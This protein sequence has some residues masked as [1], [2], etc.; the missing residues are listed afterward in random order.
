MRRWIDLLIPLLILISAVALRVQDGTI[1]TELR[2]RV[3]DT[4]QRLQPR[5]YLDPPVRILDIDE[6][7]LR[8]FG[9]WPWPR[10]FLARI[11]NRLTEAGVAAIALDMLQQEPDRTGPESLLKQWQGRPNFATLQEAIKQLP[12]PDA[13]YIQALAS[14][15]TVLAFAVNATPGGRAPLCKVNF[16][17]LGSAGDDPSSYLLNLPGVTSAL[18]AFENA[19]AG[20]GATNALPDRDGIVRRVPLAVAYQGQ[21]CGNLVAEALRVAQGAGNY[22]I[23]LTGANGEEN[24]GTRTGL[25]AI[26]IGN[27]IVP[28][29]G[30][31]Q[32]LLYDSNTRPERFLSIARFM[33]PNFDASALANNIVLIG[34]TAEG[35]KD[36]K[37]SPLDPSMAGVEINAQLIEQILGS[38]YLSRPDYAYG[39][40]LLGLVLFGLALMLMLHFLGAIWSAGVTVLAIAFANG[41]S[42]YAFS[43]HGLLYDPAFPSL[44]AVA[45]YI[46]GSLMGYLR[47][48]RARHHVHQVVGMYVSPLVVDEIIKTG[49]GVELGGE[50]RELSVMFSDI[51]DFTKIAEKLNPQELTHLI[52]ST[53][54]PLTK[55]IYDHRGMLDKYI[56][57]CIMAFWSAPLH[58]PDHARHSL[59]AA[60][61]MRRSLTQ[62]NGH[63]AQEAQMTGKP[64]TPV[65]VGIGI[66]SGPCSVGNMG[67]AQRVAYSALGDT[68]NLASRL[69]SLTRS[70]GVHI[71]VGEETASQAPEMALL[72][73]DRVQVKGRS[74]PLAIYTLL[75]AARDAAFEKL[76]E[77]QGRFLAAYRSKNWVA[78]AAA[79]GECRAL[80]PDLSEL[81]ELFER[82]LADYLRQ[83]P[84]PEWD[85]VFVAVSKTG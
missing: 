57:D 36:F 41:A 32:M 71:I 74:R 52:N 42:W 82:R 85:G 40:E 4:Y 78:A 60:L 21:H 35:L 70:Y 20:N 13:E 14:D 53:L 67:S 79:L 39:M 23:K 3:F 27:A 76:A 5:P 16:S 54:T 15:P 44:A 30:T 72:E 11:L 19:A 25:A 24:F 9:Q 50:E 1:V 18:P 83:P 55:E 51:R 63:F 81:Y 37:A 26:K 62:V 31:G 17:Y 56:G 38:Q 65:E 12:N 77:A 6:E 34:S 66:N 75:A 46:S 28:V 73:I 43:H 49:K 47:T 10:D 48:E 2:N 45:I 22:I 61:A 29:D 59:Q 58:D 68:V 8:T 69:E 33:Q 80:A 64:F 7:S 84:P